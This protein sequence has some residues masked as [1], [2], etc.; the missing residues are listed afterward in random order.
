[1]ATKFDIGQ[2]TEYI[3]PELFRALIHERALDDNNVSLI[4]RE[5]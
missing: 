1:M 5:E 3:I 2:L 4:V